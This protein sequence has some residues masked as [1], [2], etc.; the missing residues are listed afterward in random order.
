LGERG[1]K[2]ETLPA[3]EDIQKLKRRLE[4]NNKKLLKNGRKLKGKK[5]K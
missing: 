1:I 5:G 2:P 3:E 4:S